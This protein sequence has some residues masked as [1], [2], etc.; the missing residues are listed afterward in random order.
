MGKSKTNQFS[1]YRSWVTV[2]FLLATGIR[3]GELCNIKVKDVNLQEA[4]VSVNGKSIYREN[5]ALSP[6]YNYDS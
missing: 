1:E 5:F 3:I 2:N 6:N 4:V